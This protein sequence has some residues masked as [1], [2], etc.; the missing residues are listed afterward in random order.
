MKTTAK[1][2][3][4]F[5]PEDN[6]FLKSIGIAPVT[7]RVFRY[8]VPPAVPATVAGVFEVMFGEVED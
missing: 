3:S 8:A 6:Q 4:T 7:P 5:T 1:V 2:E